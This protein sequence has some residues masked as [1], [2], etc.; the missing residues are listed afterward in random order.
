MEKKR[1]IATLIADKFHRL[2]RAD[3]DLLAEALTP[4]KI[5][6]GELLVKRGEVCNYF[7]FVEKGMMGRFKYYYNKDLPEGVSDEGELITCLESFLLRRPSQV[8]IEALENT[9]SWGV[10]HADFAR[11]TEQSHELNLLYRTIL[12]HTIVKSQ[13]IADML[14]NEPAHVRYNRLLENYPQILRRAPLVHI[15]SFLQMTPE[16]LSRVRAGQV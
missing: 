6:K 3:L 9:A 11:L 10:S 13:H 8:M 1:E 12:E 5:K 15:A 16:T 2:H 14:R 4:F 7:Y